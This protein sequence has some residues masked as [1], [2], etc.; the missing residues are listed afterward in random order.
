MLDPNGEPS[1]TVQELT[2]PGV[3]DEHNPGEMFVK[4]FE[5]GQYSLDTV[6]PA[7]ASA[8]WERA[9]QVIDNPTPEVPNP[10]L[11]GF[12]FPD[13][14]VRMSIDAPAH[15]YIEKAEPAYSSH[16]ARIQGDSGYDEDTRQTYHWL[17]IG[18]EPGQE[19][20]TFRFID[21]IATVHPDDQTRVRIVNYNEP[22]TG[23]N[24]MPHQLYSGTLQS[25]KVWRLTAPAMPDSS[26]GQNNS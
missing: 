9:Y 26:P 25:Y 11:D 13:N 18:A 24:A 3:E 22:S 7:D 15:T 12:L 20:A 8:W 1:A 17:E 5:Y 23:F 21:H 6:D 14:T 4:P 16:L 2:F 10:H 19:E